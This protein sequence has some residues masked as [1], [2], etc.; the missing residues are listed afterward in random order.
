MILHRAIGNPVISREDLPPAGPRAT[1]V[2]A[3]FN[4]GACRFRDRDLLLL[5][6]QNRGRETMLWPAWS[7]DGGRRWR[8]DP[9]PVELAGLDAVPGEV[10]HVYDP[11]LTV[12]DDTIGGL[13]AIDVDDT[14]RLGLIRSDDGAAWRCEGLVSGPDVRNGVLFPE[15]IG[16]RWLRLERPNRVREE[17]GPATGDAIVLAESDDLM[18]WREVGEVMR[19]RPRRWDELIGSGPPPLKTRAGW[20]HVYHGVA[21]HFAAAN[22]YQAGVALL[23]LE[24]PSRLLARGTQNVLEPRAGYETHGQ[25]PNVVFP[26]GLIPDLVDDEG[27]APVDTPVTVYYGAADTC[28][29]AARATVGEL[30]AACSF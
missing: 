15:K 3:V 28:V 14:C 18:R 20:L 4:P 16:G 5:R 21:T 2:S 11:R 24:D 13:V 25:V 29:A 1:D 10:H 8:P 12:L 19:G 9:E 27:F 30:L 17:G 7:D 6:V 22:I 23:D 26:S